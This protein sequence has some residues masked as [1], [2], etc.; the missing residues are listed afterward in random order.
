[1]KLH[2]ELYGGGEGRSSTAGLE[3][4]GAGQEDLEINTVGAT[5]E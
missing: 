1:M 4:V 2:E 5:H 3:A